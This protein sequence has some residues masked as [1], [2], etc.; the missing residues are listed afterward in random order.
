M[1]ESVLPMFSSRSF[2][3]SGGGLGLISGQG[4]RPH[5]PQL[6]KKKKDP[7]AA[8]KMQGTLHVDGRPYRPQLRPS[9]TGSTKKQK[10]IFKKITRRLEA[11]MTGSLG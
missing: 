2:I 8:T 10:C 5:M 3:V 9:T 4:T 1:S 7:T 11:S 6:K